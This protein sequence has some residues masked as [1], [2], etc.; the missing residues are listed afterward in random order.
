MHLPYLTD[1]RAPL[2]QQIETVNQHGEHALVSIPCERPLTVYVD[3]RE[4]VTLMTLA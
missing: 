3:K 1:A 2:T 4:P